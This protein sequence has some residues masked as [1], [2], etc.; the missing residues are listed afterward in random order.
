MTKQSMSNDENCPKNKIESHRLND[1]STKARGHCQIKTT[2]NNHFSCDD[3]TANKSSPDDDTANG[4]SP[5]DKAFHAGNILSNSTFYCYSSRE[6]CSTFDILLRRIKRNIKNIGKQNF[7]MSE[8]ID[9]HRGEEDV[10]SLLKFINSSGHTVSPKES[11]GTAADQVCSLA[12]KHSK[13]NEDCKKEKG[14]PSKDKMKTHKNCSE[15]KSNFLESKNKNK[16]QDDNRTQENIAE[17][18]IQVSLPEKGGSNQHVTVSKSNH[19]TESRTSPKNCEVSGQQN[20]EDTEFKVVL[21]K[22]CK[23]HPLKK[24]NENR[25]YICTS[26]AAYKYR[27]QPHSPNARRKEISIVSSE[28]SSVD[29]LDLHSSNCSSVSKSVSFQTCSNPDPSSEPSYA[30]IAR[31]CIASTSK[32]YCSNL[33]KAIFYSSIDKNKHAVTFLQENSKHVK[34]QLVDHKEPLEVVPSKSEIDYDNCKLSINVHREVIPSL[35]Q[36]INSDTSSDLTIDNSNLKTGEKSAIFN[37]DEDDTPLP[38]SKLIVNNPGNNNCHAEKVCIRDRKKNTSVIIMDNDL[39]T[40]SICDISFGIDSDELLQIINGKCTKEEN[41]QDSNLYISFIKSQENEISFGIDS[42]ELLQI[43]N[44]KCTKEEDKQDSNLYI[45]FI[46]SQENKISFGID[47]DELL[48]IIDGKCTKEEDKQDSNLYI[49]FIK[50]QENE[51]SF[52]ID[53]DELLQIINGKCT[54]EEDKQDSNLYISFIK[55]QENEISFGIDSDELLQIING[56]C[57]KEEGKQDSNLYI[58]FIKSQENKSAKSLGLSSSSVTDTIEEIKKDSGQKSDSTFSSSLIVSSS[59]DTLERGRNVAHTPQNKLVLLKSGQLLHWR[60]VDADK[61][62]FNF[63][64]IVQFLK[65]S[66]ENQQ[67]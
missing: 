4:S 34:N 31:K 56:K 54:K 28:S 16:I 41:K 58:S 3:D 11:N 53:S 50:S 60:D 57:T 15:K 38:K 37:I 47:S 10:D 12:G 27:N 42:D 59:N 17:K 18:F 29:D 14:H 55:S 43:I 39:S 2:E 32:E 19:D 7:I 45:S 21:K 52:G 8:N 63:H 64:H 44:G 33:D 62:S 13:D 22:H 6:N 51:I 26:A 5:D 1:D 61:E 66:L 9:G 49:S 20:V 46:K 24:T 25:Y 36:C 65:K 35:E 48:Q 40:E 30:D 67:N 23:R